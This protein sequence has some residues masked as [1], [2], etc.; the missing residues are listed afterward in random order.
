MTRVVAEKAVEEA[1]QRGYHEA[2][3][4]VRLAPALA[5]W[6]GI[7]FGFCLGVILMGLFGI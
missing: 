2:S 5:L 3:V 6:A 4:E 1:F 7:S